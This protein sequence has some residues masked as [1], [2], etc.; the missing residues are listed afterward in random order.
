MDSLFGGVD[1]LQVFYQID[2]V[3]IPTVALLEM[4]EL[5]SLEDFEKSLID[6]GKDNKEKGSDTKP[7]KDTGRRKHH[8]HHHHH[9]HQSSRHHH[10]DDDPEDQHRHKRSRRSG[11]GE[12]VTSERQERKS[13][14]KA[15]PSYKGSTLGDD[16]ERVEKDAAPGM[17]LDEGDNLRPE[18]T[19][20]ELKRD[21]WMEAPSALEIE[22]TQKGVK[23]VPEPTV[24]RSSKADF[25]LKIHDNELNK[26]HLQDLADGKAAPDDVVEEP[27]Q[28]EVDYVFGDSGAQWRMTKLKTVYRQ[29]EETGR[30][31]EDVAVE[32]YGDLRAFDD[33]REEQ[34]E[35]E[36]RET[37]GKGYVG[38]QKP[39][40]EL[41]QERK[42]D[43]GIHEASVPP[44]EY[45]SY[46]L[47]PQG[48]IMEEAP[49]I[50]QTVHPDQ[51][52]LNRLKAQ[53]MKAK[54]RSS[55]DAA[56]LEIKYNNAMASF[57]NRKESDIV[58]LGTM[59]N[60]MLAGGRKGEV[61][62]IDNKRGRERGLVEENEDMSIEDMVREERRTG[63]QAGGEGQRF[64]KRIAKDG[65]FN[66]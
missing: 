47:R 11:G 29:A 38:K 26:H 22:H 19:R 50:A 25:A 61:K 18:S 5:T 45:S 40:G 58:V 43:A 15:Q 41:F 23:K 30:S 42:I 28:H 34:V 9:R 14:D 65:K 52:A 62:A 33:A 36:R 8:H 4:P 16:R 55:A 54:L 44:E 49:A 20:K 10:D 53:M 7:A 35:L 59:E 17:L 46:R 1:S 31:V 3:Y 56:A 66:V 13:R 6:S 27:A 2:F 21:S 24:S 48:E 37:Y 51:T 12:D 64:A 57:A 63:G 39:S 60:R 32:R